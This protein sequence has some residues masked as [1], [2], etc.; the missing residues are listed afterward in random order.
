MDYLRS[1]GNLTLFIVVS[2][3]EGFA[4]AGRIRRKRLLVQVVPSR[5]LGSVQG[6]EQTF[7]QIAG[8]I[9][10]LAVRYSMASYRAT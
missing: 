9:G 3:I 6:L 8:L 2:I 5:W 10:T 7:I 4:V 1:T